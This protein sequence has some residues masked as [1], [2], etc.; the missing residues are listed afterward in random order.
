MSGLSRR[1]VAV[2]PG[3]ILEA[4]A[5]GRRAQ[6]LLEG[7]AAR[8]THRVIRLKAPFTLTEQVQRPRGR[9]ENKALSTDE[10]ATSFAFRGP[11]ASEGSEKFSGWKWTA[12]RKRQ[13]HSWWGTRRVFSF[14]L[15][16]VYASQRV[17]ICNPSS[18]TH[19]E[20]TLKGGSAA[21]CSRGSLS[22]AQHTSTCGLSGG[23]SY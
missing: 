2:R 21:R 15:A 3:R 5:A 18:T 23:L 19:T 6:V 13:L 10:R 8:G 20:S 1:R 7:D 4:V 14:S 9:K 17:C 22:H 16:C 12:R 11:S